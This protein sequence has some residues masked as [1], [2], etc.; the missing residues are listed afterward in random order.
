MIIALKNKKNN[1]F[2][3]KFKFIDKKLTIH[4]LSALQCDPL[5]PVLA[6]FIIVI[7]ITIIASIVEIIVIIIIIIK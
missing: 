7:K 5:V 1:F 4:F 6:I 2:L 3:G